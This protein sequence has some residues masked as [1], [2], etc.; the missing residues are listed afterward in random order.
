M[1]RI[2]VKFFFPFDLTYYFFI[3]SH[4]TTHPLNENGSERFYFI[5]LQL[6]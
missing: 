5:K 1:Y 4:H 3:Q 2:S 6:Q